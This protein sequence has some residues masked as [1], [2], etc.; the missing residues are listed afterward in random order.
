MNWRS[1]PPQGWKPNL[2]S[3]FTT[4]RKI[5]PCEPREMRAGCLSEAR[6]LQAIFFGILKTSH[7]GRNKRLPCFGTLSK[8]VGGSSDPCRNGS[9]SYWAS[10]ALW[11]CPCLRLLVPHLGYQQLQAWLG[12]E[13]W[14]AGWK[15]DS[16]CTNYLY[17]FTKRVNTHQLSMSQEIVLQ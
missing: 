14:C 17:Q 8:S 13:E 15:Q 10:A 3:S 4:Y 1:Q 2:P 9:F 5:V 7:M 16:C 12:L 6:C 11:Q